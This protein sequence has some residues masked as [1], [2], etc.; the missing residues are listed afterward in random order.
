VQNYEKEGGS[1]W[2]KKVVTPEIPGVVKAG[3]PVSPVREGFQGSEGPAVLA[4]GS[5]LFTEQRTDKIIK[6]GVDGSV[7]TLLDKDG[8]AH[9]LALTPKG[10]LVAAETGAG[11]VGITV[12][13]PTQRV[14]ATG[15]SKDKP[16]I[17]PN[18]LAISSTGNIYVT[19]PG[20]Y[21]QAVRGAKPATPEELAKVKSGVY[22]INRKG[23]VALASDS[24]AW[25]NGI[26]LSPDEKTVYVAN[27]VSDS[28]VAFAV[29]PDG[30]LSGQRNFAKL[31][32]FTPSPQ[33]GR[34]ADGI[35]ID[36][37]GRVYAATSAGVEV[38]DA[39][40]KALGVIPTPRQPQAL[41]FGGAD[42]SRLY[43]VGR[44][45]V[46]RIA[47]LTKGPDRNGR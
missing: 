6:I 47:T 14:I 21:Q 19:D 32:G 41:V 3:T 2:D 13:Q 22:W 26:V 7:S 17:H 23:K 28:L 18:D 5:I 9:R 16:F 33:G 35:A 12:L 45:S 44:G 46:Y 27:T 40:G 25:P 8:G 38:F 30:S 1:L 34:G 31:V 39:T 42:R 29:N 37:E 4:D 15:L 24:I 43:V 20:A 36:R 10:E 11:H